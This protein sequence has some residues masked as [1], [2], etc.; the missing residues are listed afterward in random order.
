MNMNMCYDSEP[1][2]FEKRYM[3]WSVQKRQILV[4]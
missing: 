2:F 4:L 3:W 1:K